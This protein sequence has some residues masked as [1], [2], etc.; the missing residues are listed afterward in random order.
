MCGHFDPVRRIPQ[1]I[2]RT[3]TYA[4]LIIEA[5]STSPE[6]RST[7]QEILSYLAT[8]Y[9]HVLLPELSRTWQSSIRQNLSRDPRFIRLT[10]PGHP[11]EWIYFPPADLPSTSPPTSPNP[12]LP[13][14]PPNT[15]PNSNNNNTTLNDLFN[16]FQLPRQTTK[17]E[18]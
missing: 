3:T 5:I 15:S 16:D 6:G 4:D 17:D 11:S 13:P 7:T 1:R 9:P 8:T 12:N 2:N 10:H 14:S 18:N